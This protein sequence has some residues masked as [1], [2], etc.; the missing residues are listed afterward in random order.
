MGVA[1]MGGVSLFGI[2]SAPVRLGCHVLVHV[3]VHVCVYVYVHVPMLVHVSCAYKIVAGVVGAG[4][5]G[6][7]P[8]RVMLDS[9]RSRSSLACFSAASACLIASASRRV[10]AS[11]LA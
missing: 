9:L 5:L 4:G 10:P 3:H 11:C 1:G 6:G 2:C 7:P 8:S